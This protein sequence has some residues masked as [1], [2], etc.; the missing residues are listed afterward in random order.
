MEGHPYMVWYRAGIF[1][2]VEYP[3]VPERPQA[4]ALSAR[5]SRS[6][7]ASQRPVNTIRRHR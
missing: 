6:A 5:G 4:A 1:R 3:Q 2:E 7:D